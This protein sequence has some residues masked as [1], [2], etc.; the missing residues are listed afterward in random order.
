[1]ET[2]INRKQLATVLSIA[3]AA[4][5]RHPSCAALASICV[6]VNGALRVYGNPGGWLASGAYATGIDLSIPCST[7]VDGSCYVNAHSFRQIVSKS[8]A[9]EVVLRADGETFSVTGDGS[10][11]TI[12]TV[13]GDTLPDSGPVPSNAVAWNA[14]TGDLLDTIGA[15]SHA[16]SPDE[17]RPHLNSCKVE[18]SGATLR[19]VA[20]DGHR[21]AV[22]ERQID[23]TEA[24]AGATRDV[25]I[26]RKV[27]D[28]LCR[29]LAKCERSTSC[30]V[31]IGE[32][33][34]VTVYEVKTPLGSVR[35]KS[36]DA[37]FPPYRQ[38]IPRIAE[39]PLSVVVDAGD[40]IRAFKTVPA[41][42]KGT[43]SAHVAFR[44]DGLDVTGEVDGAKSSASVQ[45]STVGFGAEYA[46]G[47]G[48][49]SDDGSEKVHAGERPI[50][51]NARYMIDALES[52]GGTVRAWFRGPLDGVVLERPDR[53]GDVDVIMPIRI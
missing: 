8:K 49:Q 53:G 5:D 48:K 33:G 4:I 34:G 12:P 6:E 31:L 9:R 40:A 13:T 18:L 28:A 44:A 21:L 7:T 23:A 50:G 24:P 43:P 42:G 35:G 29:I 39:Y 45:A 46:D 22:R 37:T 51:L 26:P 30:S 27:V 11:S 20:T 15:A 10:T 41:N 38:V 17:T 3:D 19:A 36:V 47:Y 16:I 14:T 1:M 52:F 2:T 25:L 32:A